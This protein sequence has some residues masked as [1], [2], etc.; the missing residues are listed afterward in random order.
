MTKKL[1]ALMALL[2]AVLV[3]SVAVADGMEDLVGDWIVEQ[4]EVQDSEVTW[5][6]LTINEDGTGTMSDG[7]DSQPVTI[8]EN[9]PEIDLYNITIGD[10]TGAVIQVD[11]EVLDS[12]E[13]C[14]V[15]YESEESDEATVFVMDYFGDMPLMYVAP[16]LSI[17]YCATHF[18]PTIYEDGSVKFTLKDVD[19]AYID[20]SFVPDMT[21]TEVLEG[22]ALQSG[23]DDAEIYYGVYD[24]A[25]GEAGILPYEK[26]VEDEKLHFNFIVIQADG[27]C[28]MVETCSPVTENED[29]EE[30]LTSEYGEMLSSI[31]L[32]SVE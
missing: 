32:V 31:A 22:L 14:L 26:T 16:G 18:V 3:C 24:F 19:N 10:Q 20:I 13:T 7:T 27:G 1:V 6:F 12:G 4:P 5:L 11:N 17:R 29:E 15:L 21:F 2:L 30:S 8:T 23:Q 28:F 9:D 25:E